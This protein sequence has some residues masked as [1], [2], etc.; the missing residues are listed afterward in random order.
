MRLADWDDLYDFLMDFNERY[1][2]Q[3]S[4]KDIRDAIRGMLE[5]SSER[6]SSPEGITPFTEYELNELL[7]E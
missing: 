4:Q 5:K 7:T 6:R 1:N 3:Y 2:L